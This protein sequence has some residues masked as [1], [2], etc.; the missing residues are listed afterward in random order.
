MGTNW[1]DKLLVASIDFGTTFSGFALSTLH[2]YELD[3]G[4][5]LAYSWKSGDHSSTPK[6]PTCLLLKPDASFHSF[7]YDAEIKYAELAEDEEHK[8]WRYFRRFKMKLYNKENKKSCGLSQHS[9]IKDSEGRDFDALTVFTFSIDYMKR[10]IIETVRERIPNV[11]EDDIHYVLTTPA[12]WSEGAKVFMRKAAINAHIP[13][14]RL[15]I[16]LEP[17]CAAVYVLTKEL[18][19]LDMVAQQKKAMTQGS[20][21]L[22]IDLGGGTLDIAAHRVNGNFQFEEIIPPEGGPWGG[23]NINFKYEQFLQRI[24]GAPAF[25]KF[26]NKNMEDFLMMQRHFENKK[27]AFNDRGDNAKV[28]MLVSESF[29]S[30]HEQHNREKLT[31]S[32]R[33]MTISEDVEFKADKMRI[34]STLFRSFFTETIDGILETVQDVLCKI[35]DNIDTIICVGGFSDCQLLKES[36]R[37]KFPDK[38]V[39]IPPEASTTI[40][41]GAVIF[42]RDQSVVNKRISR[43]TYGLDWNEEFDPA[44]HDPEKREETDDGP[45][46]R[47]IFKT[48]IVKGDEIPYNKPTQE[49][50]AYV[51]SKYQ[52]VIEFPFYRS[53]IL[54]NPI[55]I[56]EIGCHLI[57]TMSVDIGESR[58]LDSCVKL[59]VYFG[60]TELRAEAKDESGKQYEVKFK[61][62]N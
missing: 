60:A 62:D 53:E 50:E 3:K 43:Y 1:K 16:A 47:D 55:Y 23:D 51:K 36:I 22:I 21:H 4:N 13:K 30:L 61:L 6:T 17:E 19:V 40:M 31:E 26:R 7:G 15:R 14:E 38:T 25:S 34:K 8:E 5:I 41:K 37:A 39:I 28:T 54:N 20:C 58:S 48:L 10:K 44:R 9:K 59:K 24:S 49:I 56:D 32:V 11:R 45:V 35:P 33:Q 12:I 27:C 57:G 2:D 29:R 46:C 42:G 52:T 18:P